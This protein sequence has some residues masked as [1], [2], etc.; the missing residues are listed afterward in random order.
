MKGRTHRALRLALVIGVG[1][2]A[3]SG[4]ASAAP[5][6]AVPPGQAIVLAGFTS[7]QF[8]AFFKIA[9]SGR[10]LTVGGIALNM[11][12]TSGSQFVLED[13]FVHVPISAGGKLRASFTAP[14]T[15]GS[16][17]DT[18]TATDSLTGRLNHG[19]SQLSGVW[20]LMVHYTFT[21]G[22]TDQCD[23]GPVRFTATA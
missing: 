1:A 12:C 2:A 20:Q 22:S 7:Q 5:I 19:H 9:G 4:S 16:S 8:P 3:H 17:G 14:P 15:S 23:S 11:T 10:K 13:N 6:P 18:F 21:D